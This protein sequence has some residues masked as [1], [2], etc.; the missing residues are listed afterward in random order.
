VP[1]VG[2]RELSRHVSRLVADVESTREP[3]V[4]TRHGRPIALV[5]PVDATALEDYVLAAA[6]EFVK[7]IRE[8][9]RE[10]IPNETPPAE[11]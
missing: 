8:D 10:L 5:V 9:K 7:G 2:V 1:I 4:V 3:V 6:P 11:E